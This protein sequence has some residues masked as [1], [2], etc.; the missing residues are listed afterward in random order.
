MFYPLHHC[1]LGWPLAMSN[2]RIKIL[3]SVQATGN[4]HISRA[5]EVF[6]HLEKY[7]TVDVLLSGSNCNLPVNIPV[8]FR[9]PGISLFYKHGGGLDYWKMLKQFNPI[10]I[11][12]QVFS[13]PVQHYDLIINDFDALTSLACR[14][15]RVK[16]VHWGHQASFQYKKSPRP[17]K[18][19]ALGEWVLNNYCKATVHIGLHFLPYDEGILPP[20]IKESVRKYTPENHGHLTVY[21]PQYSLKELMN[22]LSSLNFVPIH[23]FSSE[24]NNKQTYQHITCFPLGQDSFSTSMINCAGLI[25]AGGFETPAEALFMG[26]KLIVI[27]IRGQYE[28]QCNAAALS[29]MA[30]PVLPELTVHTGQLIC[31]YFSLSPNQIHQRTADLNNRHTIKDQPSN[32]SIET[33]FHRRSSI[34]SNFPTATENATQKSRTS[35]ET[36]PPINAL[37]PFSSPFSVLEIKTK[38]SR[39]TEN[40]WLNSLSQQ[41]NLEAGSINQSEIGNYFKLFSN[42]SIVDKMMAIALQ[43]QNLE[44]RSKSIVF[45]RFKK[46][47]Y[48]QLPSISDLQIPISQ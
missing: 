37:N 38:K 13:I 48:P 9:Y 1:P 40:T 27:P 5:S 7:G 34:Q 11:M 29:K 24:V 35:A 30:V 41:T 14:L 4:G 16:S 23:I 25:T 3:Y 12:R 20:V 15:R 22:N 21:L 2:K 6:S 26:K 33:L 10:R 17:D 8:K 28:Q 47:R 44:P 45:L 18:I 39:K 42:E 43:Y 31:K 19:D 32:Q 36:I 46:R